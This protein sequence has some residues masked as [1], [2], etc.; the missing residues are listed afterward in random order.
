MVTGG[1]SD[2]VQ[3]IVFPAGA[4]G[5]LG[6]G[7]AGIGAFFFAGKDVF[8]LHHARIHKHQGRVIVWNQ[9]AGRHNGVALFFKITQIIGTNVFDGLH[10]GKNLSIVEPSTLDEKWL[11]FKEVLSGG[12]IITDFI[13]LDRFAPN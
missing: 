9:R 2:I 10:H 6:C 11:F 8:E 5:F 13:V 4:H 3:I 1:I 7:G 12:E